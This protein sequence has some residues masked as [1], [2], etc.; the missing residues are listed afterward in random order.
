MVLDRKGKVYSVLSGGSKN[1]GPEFESFW[2]KELEKALNNTPLKGSYYE[3]AKAGSSNGIKFIDSLSK[4]NSFNDLTTYFKEKT[5]YID[6]WASWCL[7]C[8]KEFV[9]K[10]PSV[11]SFF[12]KHNIAKIY[13]TIDKP[14]A[15]GIWRKLVHEYQLK[16]YHLMAG[17]MLQEDIKRKIYNNS[18]MIDVPR[19]VIVKNG[20]ITVVNAFAPSEE[21]RLLKQLIE[22]GI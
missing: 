10:T 13:L 19:Y 11:D 8:R 6:L 15:D 20:E 18:S 2:K 4:I 22:K 14:H 21:D 7:P 9:T 12:I 17:T 3:K 5:L 1:P 16:G